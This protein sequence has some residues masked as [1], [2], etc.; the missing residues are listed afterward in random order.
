MQEQGAHPNNIGHNRRLSGGSSNFQHRVP[1]LSPAVYQVQSA[2]EIQQRVFPINPQAYYRDLPSV[3]EQL[4]QNQG[5]RQNSHNNFNSGVIGSPVYVPFVLGNSP[6]PH[7]IGNPPISPQIQYQ[8]Q[9]YQQIPVQY[10]GRPVLV[11]QRPPQQSHPQSAQMFIPQNQL[12]MLQNYFEHQH[13]N[14]G[15]NPIFYTNP[16]SIQ[17]QPVN[18]QQSH[19]QTENVNP[20]LQSN[21]DQP[22]NRPQVFARIPQPPT[23]PPPGY[24]T[25]PSSQQLQTPILPFAA[26]SES[27]SERIPTIKRIASTPVLSTEDNENTTAPNARNIPSLNRPAPVIIP[28]ISVDET[29]S[30]SELEENV[31]V[32]KVAKK[33]VR[34]SMMEVLKAQSPE[35]DPETPEE[36]NGSGPLDLVND[37][38]NKMSPSINGIKQYSEQRN[39]SS[40]FV[41]TYSADATKSRQN[42]LAKINRSTSSTS[43]TSGIN[44]V[45]DL[46]RD[47][48]TT[49]LL[50]QNSDNEAKIT[51]QRQRSDSNASMVDSPRM[52]TQ[53]R[54]DS[55]TSM[56]SEES[57]VSNKSEKRSMTGKSPRLQELKTPE[58]SLSPRIRNRRDIQPSSPHLQQRK[59]RESLIPSVMFDNDA[60]ANFANFMANGG[61]EN[62]PGGSKLK[63]RDGIINEEDSEDDQ[64]KEEL[65]DNISESDSTS[66]QGNQASS[67][68]VLNRMELAKQRAK[69]IEPNNLGQSLAAARYIIEN[70]QYT[71][72][73]DNKQLSEIAIR[74][75]KKLAV[76]HQMPEAQF[77]LA[78]L[79]I[80]GI[81][82]FAAKHTPDFAKAF[83]L[84][85]SAAKKDHADAQYHVA[86]C[87]EVGSGVNTS[88]NKALT[89]YRK[90]A[91]SNHPGAMF[92]LGMVLLHGELGQVKNPRDGIKWIKL[93]AKYADEK[94]PFGL[95]EIAM[96]HDTGVHNHVWRD[97]EFLVN[98]LSQAATLGYAPAQFKLGEAY[99]YGNFGV[100]IDPQKAVYYYSMAAQSDNLEAMF[101]LGGL[102]LTGA[103]DQKTGFVITQSDETAYKW[104]KKAADGGL[105]KAMFAIGY[106]LEVGIGAIVLDKDEAITWYQKAAELG[107]AK[108]IKKLNERGIKFKHL[109]RSTST[110]QL[111]S[112]KSPAGAWLKWGHKDQSLAVVKL[113]N[114]VVKPPPTQKSPFAFGFS[115]FDFDAQL[116]SASETDFEIHKR[117]ASSA[118]ISL[119]STKNDK[120]EEKTKAEKRRTIA[121]KRMSIYSPA[122]SVRAS[123][124]LQQS[125]D[126]E[127]TFREIQQLE[128]Q[129]RQAKKEENEE[130][131]PLPPL[132][133]V[134]STT[135]TDLMEEIDNSTEEEKIML[136][137]P[138]AEGQLT[139]DGQLAAAQYI[140][141]EKSLLQQLSLKSG[142]QVVQI[143]GAKPGDP[144]TYVQIN[145]SDF[146]GLFPPT[147]N[148]ET[149][150]HFAPDQQDLNALEEAHLYFGE[151]EEI[152]YVRNKDSVVGENENGFQTVVRIADRLRSDTPN[153]TISGLARSDSG[154]SG[155]FGGLMRSDSGQS[156]IFDGGKDPS[157]LR[158]LKSGIKRRDS[159]DS[160]N[161][162]KDGDKECIVM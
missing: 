97:H 112:E 98:S 149:P 94:Y 124:Y 37:V 130:E 55:A 17:Q 62:Y 31:E 75:M 135:S 57:F 83:V 24:T 12:P 101:E 7:F 132:P 13:Q 113:W 80:S 105:P 33:L 42:S 114:V 74:S 107:D 115:E 150:D 4:Q 22:H 61:R 153:S 96:L 144:P 34:L 142:P 136:V 9:Y 69:H 86:L 151:K 84:F 93:S 82:G 91:I 141:I 154:Q 121:E 71:S 102:Y 95:Y 18:Y 104:V 54:S 128:K 103:D 59:A 19:R 120:G 138:A 67:N 156:G 68:R 100:G 70:V 139:A 39:D 137:I 38:S 122:I 90:A 146:A 52:R 78:H 117:N 126:A 66:S 88:P 29:G 116:N 131:P 133:I 28:V 1:Q 25:L 16:Q 108:S 45:F 64:D 11:Q 43:I 44:T 5:S 2:S 148:I 157:A 145:P 30:K 147:I 162:D 3:P 143:P 152:M 92:R 109:K 89:H 8:Q 20:V 6:P 77:A 159:K 72:P 111:N 60:Q 65:G 53:M 49:S 58:S 118:D 160:E 76:Q 155:I 87:Y 106:F 125:P 134:P 14:N 10:Q 56:A 26:V 85:S 119:S 129:Q 51:S 127:M 41:E 46:N 48:S 35:P 161:K 63:N 123:V 81:P 99:E 50:S 79:Y 40:S 27:D 73:N 23:G 110:V 36:T 140:T 47:K 158:R 15:Q 21:R 32:D